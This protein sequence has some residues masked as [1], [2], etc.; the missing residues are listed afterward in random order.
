MENKQPKIAKTILKKTT[1]PDFKTFYRDRVIEK[2]L[3]WHNDYI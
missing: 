3:Y 2:N 1:I